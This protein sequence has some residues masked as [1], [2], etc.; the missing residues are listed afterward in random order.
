MTLAEIDDEE[1]DKILETDG[2][3][4]AIKLFAEWYEK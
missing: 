4:S 1:R 3:I 2:S